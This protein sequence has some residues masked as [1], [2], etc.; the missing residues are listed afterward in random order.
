[1]YYK[2]SNTA[3]TA[4]IEKQF[5]R[6]FRHPR[7]YQ[8]EAVF[9]GL[10]EA[11]LPIITM[12][13]PNQISNGIWGL[14]P[15]GFREDWNIFQDFSN[16]LNLEVTA[17]KKSTW[18]SESF[19]QRRCVVL[20]TGFF[21]AVLFKGHL[22]PYYV[23]LDSRKPFG[24]A[25]IYNIL[26]DGFIT[27]SILTQPSTNFIKKVQHIEEV[28]PFV[29]P[30]GWENRWLSK[31]L[32]LNKIPEI[33]DIPKGYTFEAHTISRDFFKK[34]QSQET[35]LRPLLYKNV[36]EIVRQLLP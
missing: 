10:S 36:P 9:N 13:Q 4:A 14:L 32:I 22:Y 29:I 8:P 16:T 15:Q 33:P 34:N 35:T 31:G 3:D 17:I 19:V 28:M 23:H 6:S 2:L 27:F 7:L 1:M 12:G 25:G 26:D 30:K 18:Y 21:T 24:V 20:V 11:C 5:H